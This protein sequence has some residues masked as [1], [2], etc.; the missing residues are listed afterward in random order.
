MNEI[1]IRFATSEYDRNREGRYVFSELFERTF[2]LRL[3]HSI[4]YDFTSN[5]N[6]VLHLAFVFERWRLVVPSSDGFA[7][8]EDDFGLSFG[9]EV[10]LRMQIRF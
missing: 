6:G 4:D 8:N 7:L 5:W 9:F 10:G 1:L 2:Y 3:K